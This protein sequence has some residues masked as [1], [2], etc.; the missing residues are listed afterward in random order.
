MVST[1]DMK[2]TS[3]LEALKV[4]DFRVFWSAGL[5]ANTGLF[6]Q[7]VGSAWVMT[8]LTHEPIMVALMQTAITLPFFLLA[9]PAGAL[10]DLI[11]RRKMLI[12]AQLWM[13]TIAATIGVLTLTG[14]VTPWL[15]LFLTFLM[16]NGTAIAAP[17]WSSIVP[18]LVPR[19]DLESAIGLNSAG[20]NIARGAGSAIGG[21]IVTTFGAA[22]VFFLNAVSY[23]FMIRA[24]YTWA[25]QTVP[26]PARTETMMQAIKTGLDYVR[27]STVLKSTL[28]RTVVFASAVP[29]LW[30]LISLHAR[31][32]LHAS[33]IEYGFMISAFGLGTFGGAMMLPR[34]RTRLSLDAMSVAGTSV[35]AASMG[36]IAMSQTPMHG[37]F[38]MFGCGLAYT[39][40]TSSLNVAVQLSAP[41]WVRAR[42]YSV[43]LLVF[44]GCTALSATLWGTLATSTN[45]P[46]AMLISSIFLLAGMI[47]GN[48]HKLS[49][50]ENLAPIDQTAGTRMH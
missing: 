21:V 15:L 49:H 42:A 9:L 28:V 19:K 2:N 6:M 40:K 43:Y 4:I 12:C 35:F 1:A 45:I 16:F 27:Q 25:P 33:A 29:A 32:N 10:A 17:A 8:S 37:A 41:R 50:A 26:I 22:S 39:I 3:A 5:I 20:Y 14:N 18:D 23:L 48:W 30:A 46:T 24:L 34:L 13:L 36:V 7:D 44:Q 47:V 38:G 11:D 31:Q